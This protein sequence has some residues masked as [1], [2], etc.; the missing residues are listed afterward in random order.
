MNV[1]AS[2]MDEHR[3]EWDEI[4]QITP[5]LKAS[6]DAGMRVAGQIAD[7]IRRSAMETA[8]VVLTAGNGFGSSNK[9]TDSGAFPRY[10]A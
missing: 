5:G 9:I 4:V 7:K 10:G 3:E 2:K 6:L 8:N 1:M